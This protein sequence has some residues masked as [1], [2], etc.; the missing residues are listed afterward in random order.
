MCVTS[1]GVF[2]RLTWLRENCTFYP[3][4]GESVDVGYRPCK[5]CHPLQAAALAD[6]TIAALLH[7]LDMRPDLRRSEN[8]VIK[9]DYDLNCA[10]ELHPSIRNDVP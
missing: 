2:R 1:T 10:A 6:P 8:H 3:T 9:R 4:I 7:V 5:R